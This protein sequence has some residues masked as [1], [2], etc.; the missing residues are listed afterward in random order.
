MP[1]CSPRCCPTSRRSNRRHDFHDDVARFQLLHLGS[2]EAIGR[3]LPD[4]PEAQAT[5]QVLKRCPYFLG[6][7]IPFDQPD[8]SV[9]NYRELEYTPAEN[10]AK[11]NEKIDD[12][13]KLA[14]RFSKKYQDGDE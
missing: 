2:P 11:Y 4:D 9:W 13:K 5:G 10:A 8:L 1:A 14:K 12:I 7:H 6:T 3:P